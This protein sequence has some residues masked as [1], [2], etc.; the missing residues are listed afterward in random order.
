MPSQPNPR[1]IAAEILA[2]WQGR[3][4]KIDEHRDALLAR[5]PEMDERDRALVTELV[6][7]VVRNLPGIDGEL[8]TLVD[9]GVEKMQHRLLGIL[10]VGLYQIRHL[11][12]VPAHAAVNEAVT[13]ASQL[14]GKGPAGLTN[15]VLRKAASDAGRRPVDAFFAEKGPLAAWRRHW[16]EVWGEEKTDELLHYFSRIPPVGLRRNFLR[17]ESDEQ[18]RELLRSEGVTPEPVPGRPGYA[19][20]RG[21][22]PS[23]LASF[24][25][26]RTTVQD[27]AAGLAVHVLDPRPGEKVADLCSAPGGKT[28]HIWERM[29]GEGD[30]LSVDSSMK[31]NK[32]TREGLQRLGHEGVTVRTED[33]ITLDDKGFDRVLIDVPCSGTGVAHR[34]PDLLVN[35]APRQVGPLSRIQRSLLRH[36]AGMVSSGGVLVYSTCSLEPAENEQRAKAFDKELGDRF[37]RDELPGGLDEAWVSGPGEVSVWPPR[38][39]MDGAYVVRW[40]RVQ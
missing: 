17:T 12:R 34:R 23:D 37:E 40:R 7:G 25:D 19:Y 21:V 22:K 24:R 30:L 16:M 36:A 10:R 26:G 6:Y 39:R 29:G 27:P 15:A 20:A 5:Q 11:D 28:A 4:G 13:H 1:R 18:W 38:D 33:V 14:F 9:K 3:G 2:R 8:N 32:L 31:R 35:R